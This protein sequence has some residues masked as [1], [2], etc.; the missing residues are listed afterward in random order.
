MPMQRGELD[1][2]AVASVI[3]FEPSLP[4]A[5]TYAEKKMPRMG[6]GSVARHVNHSGLLPATKIREEGETIGFA[7]FSGMMAHPLTQ[8]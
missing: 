4:H 7:L 6:C 2:P 5:L 3:Q 1:T 8:L